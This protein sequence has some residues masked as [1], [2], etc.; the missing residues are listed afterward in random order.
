MGCIVLLSHAGSTVP[1]STHFWNN[2]WRYRKTL[3]FIIMLGHM[4]SGPGALFSCSCAMASCSSSLI[5]LFS[6]SLSVEGQLSQD[7]API[8]LGSVL[9]GFRRVSK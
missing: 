7:C 1:V 4:L 3:S 8:Q 9:L 5:G 2:L 6:A